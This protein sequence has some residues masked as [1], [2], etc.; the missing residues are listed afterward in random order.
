VLKAN[1][2]RNQSDDEL[3]LKVLELR[4][5]IFDLRSQHMDSKSQKTHLIRQKRKEVARILTCQNEK[6]RAE[7]R[8]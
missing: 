8:K 2:I 3:I 7:E 1:E 5:E 4:K 6:R